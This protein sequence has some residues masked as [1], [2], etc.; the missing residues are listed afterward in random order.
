MLNGVSKGKQPV[1]WRHSRENSIDTSWSAALTMSASLSSDERES[2]R[3]ALLSSDKQTQTFLGPLLPLKAVQQVLLT[4]LRD[5]SR[6]F[7][8]W[9]WDPSVQQLLN[10]LREQNPQAHHQSQDV[11]LWFDRAAQDQW[12]YQYD[13]SDDVPSEQFLQEAEKAQ[14]DGKQKFRKG[15][16][17]AASNAFKKSLE[18]LEKYFE[19]EYYGE[20]IDVQEWDEP[21][22]ERYVTLCCNVAVCGIKMKDMSGIKEY[23]QKALAVDASSRKAL[24]AMAKLH[25]LEH[26]YED[27]YA[28][29]DQAL[30]HHPDNQELFKLRREVD[31]AREKEAAEHAE[32][33][34]AA[35][36]KL[37]EEEVL[38]QQY[39]EK[40]IQWAEKRATARDAI[41][42]PTL[43]QDAFT[44]S[45]LHTYFHRLKHAVSDR[46][47]TESSRTRPM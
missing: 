26:L 31:H 11:D 45:R 2:I 27:A 17:Y 3:V 30:Q 19:N 18:S 13:R 46:L 1:R 22:Q 34:V 9:V 40:Q 33:A 42:L 41:P 7:E 47:H 28:A 35:K 24:Y 10:R 6:S 14:D 12:T 21:M 5:R 43:E 39:A 32:V 38:N 36:K 8:D 16:F 25:L 29:I 44:A 4:F 23:A 37:E 15:D 20:E